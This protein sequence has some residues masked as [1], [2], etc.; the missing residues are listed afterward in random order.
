MVLYGRLDKKEVTH[1]DGSKLELCMRM[2]RSAMSG[3]EATT[4]ESTAVTS[5]KA[6]VVAHVG[7][8]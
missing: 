7:A 5:D 4:T 6:F 2:G 1:D 3:A 8:V